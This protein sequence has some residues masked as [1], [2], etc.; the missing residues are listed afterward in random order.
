MMFMAWF[1]RDRKR[2][3]CESTWL[4]FG[5]G[6]SPSA[7]KRLKRARRAREWTHVFHEAVAGDIVGLAS[8]G[9]VL[10][11][12]PQRDVG[13]QYAAEG[14]F[15][16]AGWYTS[17]CADVYASR[18]VVVLGDGFDEGFEVGGGGRDG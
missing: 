10:L 8:A 7:S 12:P 15:E 3:N 5:C 14:E 16:L 2:A 6:G 4:G 17:C 1:E 9:A 11:L 13:A 18:V